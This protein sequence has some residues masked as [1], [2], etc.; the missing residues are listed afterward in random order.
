[1]IMTPEC[2]QPLV[3]FGRA[4][5]QGDIKQSRN[6]LLFKRSEV[7]IQIYLM[8]PPSLPLPHWSGGQRRVGLLPPWP[9]LTEN[10]TS[11]LCPAFMLGLVIQGNVM[12][13]F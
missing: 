13:L 12:P 7:S 10:A 6:I 9:H 5:N 1:M 11:D 4:N 8:H 3:L 2:V